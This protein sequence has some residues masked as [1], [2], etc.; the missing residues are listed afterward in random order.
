MAAIANAIYR[1]TGVRMR[2]RPM[3]PTKVLEVLWAKQNN[4]PQSNGYQGNGHV[5]H[6][7]SLRGT[8]SA[9]HK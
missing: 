7:G 2:Q 4:G 5:V 9:E 6:D 1:A 3:S 8:A